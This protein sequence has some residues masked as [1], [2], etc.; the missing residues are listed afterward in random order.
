MPRRKL[1]SRK[2]LTYR[3]PAIVPTVREVS[4]NEVMAELSEILGQVGRDWR[5]WQSVSE[6]S[7]SL[8]RVF[9]RGFSQ[10]EIWRKR[11][12]WT[13]GVH[14]RKQSARVVVY[15][16]PAIAQLWYKKQA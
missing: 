11:K 13:E 9:G 10:T 15:N 6:V 4:R 5:I 1:V 7:E 14:Y 2:P 12:Q 8:T 3:P 16:L